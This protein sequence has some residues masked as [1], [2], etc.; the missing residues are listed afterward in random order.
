MKQLF[1]YNETNEPIKHIILVTYACLVILWS[2]F[3]AV[4]FFAWSMLTMTP[5]I[6]ITVMVLTYK[7]FK[8]STYA[9]QW[10]LFHIIIL[11][12]GAKYRYMGNPLFKALKEIFDLNKNYFDRLG[13]FLQGFV[14]MFMLK[15]LMLRKG[16]MKRT[17]FFYVTCIFFILGISATWEISEFI[18]A[19]ISGRE[20][21]Y[22]F[23]LESGEMFDTY[24][25]MILALI[26]GL[27]A[28]F[29][30]GKQHDKH[31]EDLKEIDKLNYAEN[32][33]Q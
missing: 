20:P 13:H 28:L 18:T 33:L 7:F 26:G 30:F 22:I 14:P 21:S 32:Q 10:V 9:Y 1:R 15:E 29:A 3:G 6:W 4:D 5:V 19:M 24:W 17:K 16:Y 12:I 25:D 23:S 2:S 31:I 8:F 11:Q 27:T